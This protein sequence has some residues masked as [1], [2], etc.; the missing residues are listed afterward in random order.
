MFPHLS[1]D[2]S[3]QMTLE[4]QS[5][6]RSTPA[7]ARLARGPEVEDRPADRP[8]YVISRS[9]PRRLSLVPRPVPTSSHPSARSRPHPD[10]RSAA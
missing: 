10:D 8:L 1:T 5:H 3:W 2:L 6:Y 9:Q 4:R 7:P